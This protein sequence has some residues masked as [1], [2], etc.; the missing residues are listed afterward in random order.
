[1]RAILWIG[2][3]FAAGLIKEGL[4]WYPD[5]AA[6]FWFKSIEFAFL[7]FDQ[8]FGSVIVIGF[9]FGVR[10]LVYVFGGFIHECGFHSVLLFVP[11]FFMVLTSGVFVTHFYLFLKAKRVGFYALLAALVLMQF[12]GA[13]CEWDW[14]VLG[15]LV[16]PIHH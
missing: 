7:P 1:M 6:P 3:F 16:L 14:G 5:I 12:F 8:I 9:Y 15:A 10:F 4:G 11:I 2:V 13:Y